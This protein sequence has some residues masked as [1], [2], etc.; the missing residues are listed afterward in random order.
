MTRHPR[1]R[2][3][4][5]TSSTTSVPTAPRRH[6]GVGQDRQRRAP[7]TPATIP[8]SAHGG[9]RRDVKLCVL[10][11]SPQTTDPDTGNTVDFKVMIHKIHRGENLPSVEAG[12]PYVII[13]NSSSRSTTSRTSSSRRTSATAQ[14]C[15]RPRDGD[16]GRR[17]AGTR[18]RARAACGSCHDDVNFGRPARTTRP[19]P[20][21]TTARAPR[22]H[23]PQGEP[24]VRR[25]DQRRAHGSRKVDTAEGPQRRDR[26]RDQ[27][28][29]GPEARRCS[30]RSP[31]T[32][33]R[34]S[35]APLTTVRRHE[36]A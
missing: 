30:S 3:T 13:G 6:R 8:L 31:R 33:G 19:D 25:V 2:T 15:H 11:H 5:P 10:C 7:A 36:H 26:P 12:T 35:L 21:P 23:Q 17:R 28:G 32:T 34:P 18:T 24:G 9:S 20:R 1:A 16:A 14:T 22:C 27:H 29:P 4:T